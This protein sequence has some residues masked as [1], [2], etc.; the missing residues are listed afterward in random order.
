MCCLRNFV[1]SGRGTGKR[2]LGTNASLTDRCDAAPV[3]SSLSSS[4]VQ[5]AGPLNVSNAKCSELG[6][7]GKEMLLAV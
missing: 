3:F 1:S 4:A 6:G 5:V 7:G 2:T